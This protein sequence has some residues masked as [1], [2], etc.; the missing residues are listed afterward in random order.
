VCVRARFA[1][2]AAGHLAARVPA[3][4]ASVRGAG[5]PRACGGAGEEGSHSPAHFA[6]APPRMCAGWRA[7]GRGGGSLLVLWWVRAGVSEGGHGGRCGPAR[8]KVS[9]L[10]HGLGEGVRVV[11][12]SSVCD[13][14]KPCFHR[15]A[16]SRAALYT[17]FRT[18]GGSWQEDAGGIHKAGAVKGACLS[19]S[20]S[21]ILQVCRLPSVLL[22]CRAHAPMRR[23]QRLEAPCVFLRVPVCMAFASS[24]LA[25]LFPR[26]SR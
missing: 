23:C 26:R 24:S 11:C 5:Q 18:V 13:E 25:R 9:G 2:L 6:R 4:A 22:V 3:A 16:L 19:A 8:K 7:L 15:A 10:E 1:S 17:P 14:V 21:A 12:V 20:L